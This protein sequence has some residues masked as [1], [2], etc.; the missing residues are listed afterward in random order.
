M[1]I[2]TI[3]APNKAVI[4]EVPIRYSILGLVFGLLVF[5]SFESYAQTNQIHSSGVLTDSLIQKKS[6]DVQDFLFF[7][8][9]SISGYLQPQ[10]Q[11]V[12]SKG[13]SSIS[14]GNFEPNTNSRIIMRRG[15][16]KA[17]F[18]SKNTEYVIQFNGTE[19]GVS[20]DEVYIVLSPG[21][22]KMI[23]FTTGIFN[24]PFSYEINYSSSKMEFPERSRIFRAL[25]PNEKDMGAMLTIKPSGSSLLGSFTL[26]V[27]LFNGTG[28]YNR[29]FD[30][31]KD[32]IAHF[33]FNQSSFSNI[34]KYRLGVSYESG[35][36]DNQRNS[37]YEWG[38]GFEKAENDSL[39]RSVRSFS[40]IEGELSAVWFAGTT[41]FRSEYVFG[42]QSSTLSS[43][44]TPN[45]APQEESATRN[46]TGGYLLFLHS[47]P[48]N[49]IQLVAKFD[50]MDP[51]SK[52]SGS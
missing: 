44:K 35:G 32:F 49:K 24:R 1:R 7:K 51:N 8:K 3:I 12:E 31:R 18:T 43:N 38:N 4:I 41:Q 40:G 28:P 11:L 52:I 26:D 46:F 19:R 5:V 34:F 29:D 16:L 15:R 17:K 14:G 13:A 10:F 33:Y 6:K 2:A 45:T 47:F 39:A 22:L 30:N 21:F 23:S 42:Q 27:G 36:F 20:L 37:H 48:K 50:W 25:C 9:V